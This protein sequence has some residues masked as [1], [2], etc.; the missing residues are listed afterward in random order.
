VRIPSWLISL[1]LAAVVVSFAL[2]NRG[3]ETFS[4]W[5]LPFTVEAPTWAAVFVGVA[6][7][8]LFGALSVWGGRLRAGRRARREASR[9]DRALRELEEIKAAR[10]PIPEPRGASGLPTAGPGGDRP[11]A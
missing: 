7:G 9:A 5:P 11:A 3:V 2:S 10:A 1:P 6:I 8:F 4:L